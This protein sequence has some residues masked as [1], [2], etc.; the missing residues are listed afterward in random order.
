MVGFKRNPDDDFA[1]FWRMLHRRGHKLAEAFA[2]GPVDMYL[3][4]MHRLAGHFA[5]FEDDNLVYQMLVCRNLAWW[6]QER[7]VW[8]KTK[9]GGAHPQR[10]N[11]WR[12]ESCLERACG[13]ARLARGEDP[14]EVG[15]N[16]VAQNKCQW[17]AGEGAF[18]ASCRFFCV[19]SRVELMEPQRQ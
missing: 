10:F 3:R 17:R 5:R 11:A 7:R 2:V 18:L 9:F 4:A 12:W 19:G 6:R 1:T 15:W 16:A 8:G 14:R 13:C